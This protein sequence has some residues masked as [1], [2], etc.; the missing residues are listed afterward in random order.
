MTATGHN[1]VNANGISTGSTETTTNHLGAESPHTGFSCTPSETPDAD[2][3]VCSTEGVPASAEAAQTV[4]IE[5]DTTGHIT[6]VSSERA[7]DLVQKPTLNEFLQEHAAAGRIRIPLLKALRVKS[8][9]KQPVDPVNAQQGFP[10]FVEFLEQAKPSDFEPGQ[11]RNKIARSMESPKIRR[12]TVEKLSKNEIKNGR[13][14]QSLMHAIG[15]AGTQQVE[16]IDQLIELGGSASVNEDARL[17]AIVALLQAKCYNH[18]YAIRRLAMLA[19]PN[20]QTFT[21]I[22]SLHVQH[23]LIAHA[24]HCANN[25]YTEASANKYGDILS[26]SRKHLA[27]AAANK[28]DGTTWILLDAI[29]NTNSQSPRETEAVASVANNDQLLAQTRLLAVRTLGRLYTKGALAVLRKL[30]SSSDSKMQKA[31]E[32]AIAGKHLHISDARKP[33]P[34]EVSTISLVEVAPRPSASHSSQNGV[35]ASQNGYQASANSKDASRID[36]KFQ[37]EIPL[38]EDGDCRAEPK[39]G[40]ALY[41]D[42]GSVCLKGYAGVDGKVWTWTVELIQ[43]GGVQC[44]GNIHAWPLCS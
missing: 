14:V 12:L 1:T 23:G 5:S 3:R 34:G 36:V 6:L 22:M 42:S 2:G 32:E 25:K 9:E 40:V 27:D 4:R 39:V 26:Q 37:V 8:V 43:G 17:Q 20:P 21:Q 13:A 15:R 33:P 11:L 10:A 19:K 44:S 31:A 35:H 28:D 24:E 16:A 41:E 18:D 38:P 7:T 30:S 29:G